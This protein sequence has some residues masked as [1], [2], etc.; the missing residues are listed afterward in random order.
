MEDARDRERKKWKMPGTR[1]RKKW[2]MPG[3]R[4]S[5]VWQGGESVKEGDDVSEG[6]G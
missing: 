2:K 1:E 3:K 6:R 4:R 5:V